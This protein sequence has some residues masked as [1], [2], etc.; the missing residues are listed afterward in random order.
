MLVENK[1]VQIGVAAGEL[2][3]SVDTIRRWA[4]QGLIKASRDGR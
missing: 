4:K 2:K 1:L 3:V